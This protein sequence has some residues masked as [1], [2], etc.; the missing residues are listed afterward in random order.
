MFLNRTR[1]LAILEERYTSD[2]AEL[3]VLYGRRRVGKTELLRAFCREKRHVFFV[4]DLGSEALLLTAFSRAIGEYL[5]GPGMPLAFP[6]W[7]TA[8]EYL[9]ST[10]QTERLV[11][12]LDEFGYLT[13]VNPAFPSLL[14]RLW[15]TR[16]KD[17]QL[18]ARGARTLHLLC[19]LRSH[20]TGQHP[21][22]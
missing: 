12:V 21:V 7:D 15:D 1:E 5:L 10:A 13:Q 8:F 16:L 3:F 19:H 17:T 9:V 2:Q 14:Q 22:Q 18:V 4:A 11:V 20:G 6:T